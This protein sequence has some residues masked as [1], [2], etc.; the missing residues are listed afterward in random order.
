MVMIVVDS[1]EGK[2]RWDTLVHVSA[3]SH[4]P[5]I[6]TALWDFW[7]MPSHISEK[8]NTKDLFL[9]LNF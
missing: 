5:F 7:E 4:Q 3:E 2:R 8:E 1:L 9:M 6:N